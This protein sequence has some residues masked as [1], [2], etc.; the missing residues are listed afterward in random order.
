MHRTLKD[1]VI[2][3]PAAALRQQQQ[4]FERFRQEFNGVRPHESLGMETPVSHYRASERRYP[5]KLPEV[6]YSGDHPVRR[7]RSNG[8]IKWRGEL[9]Y[10]SQ[11]LIG[12]PVEMKEHPKGGWDLY[13]HRYRLGHL[14][15][16]DGLI[17]PPKV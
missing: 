5:E 14:A 13:F 11:A 7:V 12:E 2:T 16:N 15:I 9:I 1:S 8:E 10:T 4:A 6:E 17:R 3:P